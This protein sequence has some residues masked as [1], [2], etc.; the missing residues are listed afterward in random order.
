[1]VILVSR[2][3]LAAGLIVIASCASGRRE[4]AFDAQANALLETVLEKDGGPGVMA[5]V[6]RD[7]ELV[8]SGA[9]GFADL[10]HDIKLTPRHRLR[11][12]SVSKPIAASLALR[13][14]D[15]GVLSLDDDVSEYV[16]I[17]SPKGESVSLYQLGTHVSGVRHYDFSDYAEANNTTYYNS[18]KDALF[19]FSDEPLLAPPG[20]AFTYSSLAYN[21]LG[22]A[23]ENAA[24]ESYPA[25]VSRYLAAPLGLIDTV[26]DHPLD[27]IDRRAGF[28]TVTS[29]N[30]VFP[31][32]TDGAVINTITRD[33]S[34]Y[35]P[36]GGMLSTAEDL[37]QFGYAVF[38]GE[39]LSEEARRTAITPARL[40][41]GEPID[42]SFGWQVY[43]DAA[44]AIKAY[45]HN[46]E[47]N[48]GYA[49]LRVF[50]DAGLVV[51]GIANYNA[52]G[53]EPAFF[54]AIEDEL[55]VLIEG[56]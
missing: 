22:A 54:K 13:L 1:M 28:Y 47:T 27:I 37:A 14:V 33:S 40:N 6:V 45:G 31:W 16:E 23:L 41:N 52:I 10:E 32:M 30:P 35:Y 19:H 24:G 46:G 29:A 42:Y 26:A 7:G 3:L 5:A 15:K 9:A 56:G 21:L 2:L 36:S 49:V 25:L 51:A 48:G 17:F 4:T 11:I 12:G 55:P 8:W 39:F 44:G 53:F 20:E 38:M 34:D 18:L 43:K 50:P